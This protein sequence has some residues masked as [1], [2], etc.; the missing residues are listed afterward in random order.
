MCFQPHRVDTCVWAHAG[1]RVA[2]RFHDIR[3]VEVDR[4]CLAMSAGFLQPHRYVVNR[5][6]LLGP[7]PPGRLNGEL[8]HGS[9]SPYRHGIAGLDAA[10]LGR[11][12]AG[13]QNIGKKQRL[14][15]AQ[16]FGNLERTNVRIRYPHVLGLAAS[17]AAI[18][19]GV[20]EQARA[21]IAVD[22]FGHVGVGIGV[23][24]QRPHLA[25]TEEAVAAGNGKRYHHAVADVQVMN[26]RAE[27]DHLAHE[28]MTQDIP[29]FHGGDHT[30]VQ[31]KV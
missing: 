24:A 3:F 17:I 23:V 30:V 13:R 31:V 25:G 8:P 11:H 12:K 28:F 21:R 7:Q 6:H 15:V 29:F 9:A 20:S 4:F 27:F 18:Q 19:M 14:L 5:N 2:Q 10:V 22:L 26:G 16:A 1:S